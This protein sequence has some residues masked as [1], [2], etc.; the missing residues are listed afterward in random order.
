M[1]QQGDLHHCKSYS[2]L[3]VNH[4]LKSAAMNSMC[5]CTVV[6]CQVARLPERN[7]EKERAG[8][9]ARA[10]GEWERGE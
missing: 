7:R 9:K 2:I 6:V 3:H 1:N 8:S 5:G 10:S 4:S